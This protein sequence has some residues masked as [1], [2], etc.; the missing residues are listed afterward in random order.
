[1]QKPIY[2]IKE[3]FRSLNQTLN[4][5]CL[6]KRLQ[7]EIRDF[8]KDK[9]KHRFSVLERLTKQYGKVG[10][11]PLE[12]FEKEAGIT[13]ERNDMGDYISRCS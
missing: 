3:F 12:E 7:E 5:Y 13:K 9:L 6:A 10:L 8:E 4:P 2:K 11:I 1:M